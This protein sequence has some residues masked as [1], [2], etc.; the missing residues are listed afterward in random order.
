MI[1][2]LSTFNLIIPLVS[3][4]TSATSTEYKLNVYLWSGAAASPPA[5]PTYEIT[6]LNFESSTGNDRINIARLVNDYIEFMPVTSATTG[7]VNAVN[8]VWCKTTVEY[9]TGNG[10]D[11]GVE[12]GAATRIVVKGYGSG[13]EG[14][15]PA[16]KTDGILIDGDLFRIG[17]SSKFQIPLY[18]NATKDGTVISYPS[19]T[20]IDYTIDEEIQTASASYIKLLNIVAPA[21]DEYIEITI[22]SRVITLIIVDEYK[23][24]PVDLMF[25]NKHGAQQSITFFKERRDTLNVNKES[26]ESISGY[27][28]A[29]YHQFIDFNLQG[30]TSIVLTSGFIPE[31]QNEAIK[32]L[33][34]S[35]KVWMGASLI[36]VNITQ[37][38][39]EFKTRLNDR[40]ISYD[41]ELELSYS[42]IN[43]I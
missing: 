18:L 10:A 30:K 9:T 23:Y 6:K 36:P 14:E 29:G 11:T 41:L 12:Q 26:Y 5:T 8:Q 4:I 43:T 21:T 13:L 24:T 31:D 37:T 15:N 17:R 38:S 40:L 28:S 7:T 22:G 35:H 19:E 1:K 16:A 20:E 33:M 34:L 39:Q 2:S 42:E 27:A 32:Q 25:V 3:Q